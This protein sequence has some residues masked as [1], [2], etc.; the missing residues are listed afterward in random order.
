[1]RGEAPGGNVSSEPAN[2]EQESI[3]WKVKL[4][5]VIWGQEIK[6]AEHKLLVDAGAVA[7]SK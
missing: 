4:R 2:C 1:M 5:T 3:P 6:P 7:S